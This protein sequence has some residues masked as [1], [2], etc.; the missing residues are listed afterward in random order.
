M[1][2]SNDEKLP[3]INMD[4]VY[5][6][7]KIMREQLLN[8][9]ELLEDDVRLLTDESMDYAK[10]LY[11]LERSLEDRIDIIADRLTQL[12]THEGLEH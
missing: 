3:E 4:S 9:I 2:P 10:Q 12:N 8:R 7:M 6:E 5:D 11:Y 1:I